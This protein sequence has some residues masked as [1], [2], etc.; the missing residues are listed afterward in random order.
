[1]HVP[2]MILFEKER[3]D[4]NQLFEE[5]QRHIEDLVRQGWCGWI[6]IGGR[7]DLRDPEGWGDVE[8]LDE[9]EALDRNLVRVKDF[10]RIPALVSMLGGMTWLQKDPE[11]PEWEPFVRELFAKCADYSAVICDVHI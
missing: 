9:R 8:N 7:F 5:V 3:P 2:G 1:M 10:D 11:D 4:K 6:Q